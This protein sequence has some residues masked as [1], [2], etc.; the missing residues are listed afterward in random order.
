MSKAISMYKTSKIKFNIKIKQSYQKPKKINS[1]AKFVQFQF[2][3]Y[4]REE[5]L[6]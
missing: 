3:D 5:K 4:I 6:R 2:K 1:T